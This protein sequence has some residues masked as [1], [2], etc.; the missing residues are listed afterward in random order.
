VTYSG[1]FELKT[2]H[3]LLAKLRRDFKGIESSD[4]L[5]A[6]PAFDFGQSSI[7]KHAACR[8]IATEL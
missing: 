8:E 6:D 4:R 5:D 3:D 1:F 2:P 7:E